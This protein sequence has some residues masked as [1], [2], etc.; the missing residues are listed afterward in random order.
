MSIRKT[1]KGEAA[2]V[3]GIAAHGILFFT[4]LAFTACTATGR[5]THPSQLA[6]PLLSFSPPEVERITLDC[7]AP[8]YLLEDHTIPL[9]SLYGIARAGSAYDPPGKEGLASLTAAVMRT[10]GT[11]N[12]RADELDRQIEFMGASVSA[13]ANEDASILTL[14]CL[15]KDVRAAIPL[16]LDILL[17]PAF[18]EKKIE[19]R[20]AQVREAI[21]RWNDEP[22]PIVSREFRRLVYGTY[23]YA[24]PVIGEPGSMERISREDLLAFHSEHLHPSGMILGAAGDFDRGA[25]VRTLNSIL[26]SGKAAVPNPL[27][28][29]TRREER[30]VNYIARPTEQA[31]LVIGHLGIRR[32]N[33]D[34]IPLMV[35]NEVLGGGA[36]SSRIMERIR[37]AEGLAYHAAS[38]FTSNVQTGFFSVV[39]QTKEESATK[40]LSQ[41]LE[42]LER[43]RK[44]PVTE[45]ELSR[46]KDAYVNS[47]VFHFTSPDQSVGQ[48]VDIEFYGLPRDYLRTY[49]ARVSAVTRDDVL[50]VAR[51]YLHPDKATILILGDREKFKE[52]LEKFGNVRMVDISAGEEMIR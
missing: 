16:A 18:D 15:S 3:R 45:E 9:F 31:H 32:D 14:S 38:H 35:M 42:E 36:F 52:P 44:D 12:M 33:P 40:A 29:V 51:I 7:G 25:L 46:A 24:H 2:Q 26:G 6:F 1:I 8:L 21:R 48:M 19:L 5:K 41:I 39:C 23:P 27:P 49:I 10:G 30:S 37:T 4:L 11:K 20:K 22:S 47:F 17:H 43:I 13:S 34:Y 50:R 28:E